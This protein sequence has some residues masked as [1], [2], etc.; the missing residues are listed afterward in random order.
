[1]TLGLKVA[2]TD[3]AVFTITAADGGRFILTPDDFGSPIPVTLAQLS[4]DYQSTG[5][6]K[7]PMTFPPTEAEALA[8][9]DAARNRTINQEYGRA[10]AGVPRMDTGLQR[11][12]VVPLAGSPEAVFRN[13]ADHDDSARISEPDATPKRRRT[14]VTT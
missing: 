5:G 6:D 8:A 3:G 14:K 11:R 10:V 1:M 12:E 2:D 9:A 13:L 4:E 7:L